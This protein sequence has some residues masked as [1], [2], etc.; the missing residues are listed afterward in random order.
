M[1]AAHRKKGPTKRAHIC[2]CMYEYASVY[3]CMSMLQ[4]MR[5]CVYKCARAYMYKLY[6]YMYDY[7]QM[8]TQMPLLDMCVCVCMQ[9]AL[10]KKGET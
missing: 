6:I 5:V 9:N 7:A 10:V 4:Y 2:I 8:Y 3:V 1:T